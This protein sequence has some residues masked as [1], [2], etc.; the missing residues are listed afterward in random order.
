MVYSLTFKSGIEET[1]LDYS[2]SNSVDLEI[3][4]C[5]MK[6]PISLCPLYLFEIVLN[7]ELQGICGSHEWILKSLPMWFSA[8]HVQNNRW[9]VLVGP[10]F[11]L[12]QLLVVPGV[13]LIVA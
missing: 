4:K 1:M 13:P 6:R 9:L 7:Q 3:A 12:F 2:V 8:E 5:Q 10:S 11:S